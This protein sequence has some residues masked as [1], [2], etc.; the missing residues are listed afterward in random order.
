M[1]LLMYG[2]AKI[3]AKMN[4]R[5]PATRPDSAP[6]AITRISIG[7]R[8]CRLVAGEPEEVPRVMHP[9]VDHHG[10]AAKREHALVHADEVVNGQREEGGDAEDNG[11]PALGQ[12]LG[13]DVRAGGA[14]GKCGAAGD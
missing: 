11:D 6:R 12:G 10:P 5:I 1:D 4:P 3:L 9:F 13:G 8:R 2:S 7:G 14:A